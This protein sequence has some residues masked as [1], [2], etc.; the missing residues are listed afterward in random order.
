[1]GNMDA[2]HT[3]KYSLPPLPLPEPPEKMASATKPLTEEQ[4]KEA[5]PEIAAKLAET[6]LGTEFRD[7]LAAITRAN[8]SKM[9]KN[10][11][12]KFQIMCLKV[13]G[14]LASHVPSIAAAKEKKVIEDLKTNIQDAIANIDDHAQKTAKLKECIARI[15]ADQNLRPEAKKELNIF[16]SSL[17][18][19]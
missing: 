9:Q 19:K 6:K 13:M 11:K 8:A 1:M 10:T 7:G 16:I 4:I 3:M 15:G 5:N 18:K 2:G 14:N 12:S 17:L